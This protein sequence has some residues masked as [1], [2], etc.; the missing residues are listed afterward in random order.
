MAVSF[1]GATSANGAAATATAITPTLAGTSWAAGDLVLVVLSVGAS[2]SWTG[3]AGWTEVHDNANSGGAAHTGAVYRRVMQSGDSSTPTFTA[4]SAG[5]WAWAALAL[6]PG[7]GETIAVDAVAT[8]KIVTTASE[9]HTP[10]S[11]AAVASSVASVVLNSSRAD[12]LGSSAI[13]TTPPTSWTEP[14][15][16]DNSTATGTTNATRQVGASLS[17]RLAQTGT[18]APGVETISQGAARATDANIYHLLVSATGSGQTQ[19]LG[20]ASETSAAQALSRSKTRAV[21][22]ASEGDAA[23]AH[24]PNKRATLGTAT[25]TATGQ[26]FT[27]SHSRALPPAT[28]TTTAQSL[29][30]TKRAALTGAAETD[31]AQSLPGARGLPVPAATETAGARPLTGTKR[32]ALGTAVETGA[33]QPFGLRKTAAAGPAAETSAAQ[34]AGRTKARASVPAGESAAAR[35][36]GP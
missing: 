33:G 22:A 34:P 13:T 30:R 12:I 3:P 11:V 7:A 2:T 25:E 8:A 20:T 4:A 32:R 18:V 24:G 26:A 21:S 16:G 6:S 15:G 35:P 19:A 36:L 10:N 9:T 23:P 17:Y 28:E 14:T 5:K 29:A 31:A 1:R 27:D